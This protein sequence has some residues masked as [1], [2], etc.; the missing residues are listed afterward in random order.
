MTL[1]YYVRFNFIKTIFIILNMK[2]L[3]LL[4]FCL[5][6]HPMYSHIEMIDPPPRRSKFSSFYRN[7]G[8]VDYN[9][10]A[11]INEGY[12]FPCKG[13]SEGP[14]TKIINGNTIS[15]TLMGTAIHGGGHCQF[16]I[17]IDDQTFIVLKTVIRNCLLDRMSYS[18]NLPNNLPNTKITVFWT[19]VNAIGNREYYMDCADVQ[20]RGNSIQT[21]VNGKSLLVLNLPGYQTVPEF[22]NFG[23]YDGRELFDSR[24]NIQLILRPDDN[25]QT[26][27]VQN[28]VNTISPSTPRQSN[29]Q[30]SHQNNVN[31]ISPST[32]RQSNVQH[33]HQNNVNTISNAPPISSDPC[34]EKNQCVHGK[35]TC[36]KDNGFNT[37]VYGKTIWRAC[38]PGTKCEEVSNSIICM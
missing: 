10:M 14:A 19:W 22:P 1:L 4:Y 3:S 6:I 20:L 36:G 28:N 2:L 8:L 33:S 30:H 31:A 13:Y 17:S 21:T 37:C 29:V 34:E 5:M 12:S 15:I 16:G 23:M 24:Q 32:P 38:A 11:P 26:Q 9:L 18:F 7:A 25:S 35:M 27:P